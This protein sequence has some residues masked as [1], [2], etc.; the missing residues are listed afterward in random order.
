MKQTTCIFYKSKSLVRTSGGAERVFCELANSLARGGYRIVLVTNDPTQG[1]PFYPLDDT[2]EFVNLGGTKFTGLRY[3]VGKI[4]VASAAGRGLL[5]VLPFFDQWLHTA[6]I[7][8]GSIDRLRP[9]VIVSC[10][11]TNLVELTYGRQADV[12]IVQMFHI[13]PD[14]A[15][16]SRKH[17][18]QELVGQA[19]RRVAACQVLLEGDDV[20]LRT[21]YS[22]RIAVIG[23]AVRPQDRQVVYG[24]VA[25]RRRIIYLARLEP[26][27]Q[28]DLL[29]RAFARVARSHPRWDVLLFGEA[30]HTKYEE[31]L[32][33]L[34]DRL[35]LGER[36]F[37]RGVTAQPIDELLAAD[38]CAF[39][40]SS[41]GFG[42]GL[43]EAMGVGLPCL[44]L[45]EAP[46]VNRLIRDGETGLLVDNTPEAYAA[47]L[48]RLMDDAVLREQLGTA[49]KEAVRAYAP[50]QI[51]RRWD[52]LLSVVLAEAGRKEER[53]P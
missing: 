12:P 52:E 35:G 14:A 11:L 26:N 19:L 50:E 41:E 22:G 17:G 38:I 51:R 53:G 16:R 2:V 37:L 8:R 46:G 9:D 21:R 43:A 15:F 1:V 25:G 7:V 3:A 28:Q 27:K 40:S 49:A 34:V 48:E 29:I 24:S 10:S 39:P 45:R 36:V 31:R 6:R 32:R 13:P 5:R 30:R 20:L 18:R 47:G 4:L 33:T 42:L 23:N 44:G